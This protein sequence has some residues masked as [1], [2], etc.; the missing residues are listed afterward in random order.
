M[1]VPRAVT[2]RAPIKEPEEQE[3]ISVGSA[4]AFDDV[5]ACRERLESTEN[6]EESF[7]Y[8]DDEPVF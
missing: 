3:R 5:L 1:P 7:L 6:E 2:R 4:V 8:E